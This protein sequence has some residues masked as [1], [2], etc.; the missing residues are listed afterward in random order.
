MSNPKSTSGMLED[1]LRST[2]Q[3]SAME[4]HAKTAIEKAD[5]ELQTVEPQELQ[6]ALV[7]LK[8]AETYLEHVTDLRRKGMNLLSEF[9]ET[10]DETKWCEVKHVLMAS[11]SAFEAYQAEPR[12]TK[13]FQFYLQTNNLMIEVVSD[14]LGFDIPP[15]ASCFSDALKGKKEEIE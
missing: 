13:L 3:L 15:C 4:L 1:L 11:Y 5:H 9:A 14:F 8:K 10:L 12:N 7:K 6:N 2:Q